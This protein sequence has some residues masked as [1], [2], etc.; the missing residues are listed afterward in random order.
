MLT[1]PVGCSYVGNFIKKSERILQNPE[2]KYTNLYMKN[3]DDDIT[4]EL[5]DLKFSEFG[6]VTNVKIA[7]DADGKS[8]GFGF[9]NFEDPDCAKRALES[10]NG[11]PLGK[12][13]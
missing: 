10:M 2:A 1:G 13:D 5:I 8:K 4:E 7:K 6:K 3:L 12:S 11:L 9:V